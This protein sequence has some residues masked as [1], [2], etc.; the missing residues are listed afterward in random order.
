M[1][2]WGWNWFFKIPSFNFLST[3]MKLPKKFEKFSKWSKKFKLHKKLNDGSLGYWEKYFRFSDMSLRYF[4]MH[5]KI[6]LEAL[7]LELLELFRI[8]KIHCRQILWNFELK[9]SHIKIRGSDYMVCNFFLDPTSRWF[10]KR[11]LAF[12]TRHTVLGAWPHAH[13]SKFFFE[14]WRF[15]LGDHKPVGV[16]WEEQTNFGARIEFWVP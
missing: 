11:G 10:F 5:L 7:F 2:I 1:G 8:S 14:I 4:K 3:T 15:F 13:S 16:L 12:P 6:F 9:L